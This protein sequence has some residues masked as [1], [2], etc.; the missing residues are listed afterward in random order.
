[1]KQT[2]ERVAVVVGDDDARVQEWRRTGDPPRHAGGRYRARSDGR[3]PVIARCRGLGLE[4]REQ[5]RWR[6]GKG[7]VVGPLPVEPTR[8]S[9]HHAIEDRQQVADGG[10]RAQPERQI[11]AGP[12]LASVPRSLLDL[13]WSRQLTRARCSSYNQFVIT[14]FQGNVLAIGSPASFCAG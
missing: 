6:S 13:R 8:H 3:W 5:L 14:N 7:R 1:M 11:G 2:L 12:A 4:L 9:T 10:R